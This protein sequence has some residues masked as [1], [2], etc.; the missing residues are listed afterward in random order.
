MMGIQQ[1]QLAGGVLTQARGLLLRAAALDEPGPQTSS[2]D[3]SS[4]GR[5]L[6]HWDQQCRVLRVGQYVVKQYKRPS[7]NQEMILAAFEEEDWPQRIDDPLPP[8]GEQEPKC[9]LHDTIKWLNRNHE[10]GL[11]RFLGDDTGEGVRWQLVGDAI[12]AFPAAAPKQTNKLRS[13]A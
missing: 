7:P 9:R 3:L 5:R 4:R 6:P 13:A 10:H 2:R 1:Q 12:L 11:I 8:Q